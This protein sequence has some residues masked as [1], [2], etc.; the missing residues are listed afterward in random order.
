MSDDWKGW[1]KLEASNNPIHNF[2]E[3]KILKGV[4][5]SREDNVGPNNSKLYTIEKENGERVSVWGNTILDSRLKNVL[6]GE[7]VGIA[8]LG[9]VV[10]PKTNREYHNF[11]TYHKP[12][13]T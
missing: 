11:E 12:I 10:N 5:V 6:E 7:E 13:E 1:K 9:K 2:E 3:E 8:Y 4:F